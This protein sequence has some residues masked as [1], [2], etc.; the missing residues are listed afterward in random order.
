MSPIFWALVLTTVVV[1]GAFIYRLSSSVRDYRRNQERRA[2]DYIDLEDLQDDDL[3]DDGDEYDYLLFRATAVLLV[4]TIIW[5]IIE[6][7]IKATH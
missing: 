7:I 6:G 5:G 4:V 3:L 1:G 2:E